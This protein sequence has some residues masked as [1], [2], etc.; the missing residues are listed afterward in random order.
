ME[1]LIGIVL[2]LISYLLGSIPVGYLIG[3]AKG[4]DI[5]N[6]GSKNIGSTNVSR[7][8][9][10]KYGILTFILDALKGG[11]ILALFRY[12]IIP[13][14]YSILDPMIYGFFAVLGSIFPV[15]L[16]FKGGKAVATSGGVILTY[17]P[18]TFAIVILVFFIT[19]ATSRYVSL[20]SVLAAITA[21][22]ASIIGFIIGKDLLI[23]NMNY[24]IYYPIVTILIV[25]II[26]IK[27]FANFKRI[28]EN[29]ES[30]VDW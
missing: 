5:R 28:K 20:G 25:L 27:H 6:H 1:I 14:E 11:L 13:I 4:I 3:K 8:L 19:T 26:I 2:I 18:I 12:N 29:N 21:L 17:S 16:K 10:K 24:S 9:G 23:S 22:I 15:F 7:T 30:K